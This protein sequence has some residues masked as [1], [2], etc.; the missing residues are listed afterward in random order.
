MSRIVSGRPQLTPIAQ[1]VDGDVVTTRV[2]VRND[3]VRAAGFERYIITTTATISG[4]QILNF[5]IARDLSDSETA[6][7]DAS[8]QAQH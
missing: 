4:T 1:T 3:G 2:E 5:S 7:F 8:Q 6:A